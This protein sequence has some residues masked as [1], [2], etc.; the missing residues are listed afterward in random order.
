VA[1]EWQLG[2]AHGD[3]QLH[4]AAGVHGLARD[5]RHAELLLEVGGVDGDPGAPGKVH[6]VKHDDDRSA[7]I[8]DL[9][10]EVEVP[11]EVARV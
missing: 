3:P 7:E 1:S 11:L 2:A 8:K 9:V 10:R 6:H 5:D 4:D